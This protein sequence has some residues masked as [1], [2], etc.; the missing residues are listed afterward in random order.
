VAF[1][2]PEEAGLMRTTKRYA[3]GHNQSGMRVF[4][5]IVVPPVRPPRHGRASFCRTGLN[6]LLITLGHCVRNNMWRGCVLFIV[7][8]AKLGPATLQTT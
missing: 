7:L 2:P 3:R 8:T 6:N 1:E 4:L 5:R